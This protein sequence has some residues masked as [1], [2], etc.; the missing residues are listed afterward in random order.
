MS[1]KIQ[2]NIIRINHYPAWKYLIVVVVVIIMFFS[3]LPNVYSFDDAVQ[4]K[5]NAAEYVLSY[6]Q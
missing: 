4:I 6:V 2:K 3:A 5:E 1:K